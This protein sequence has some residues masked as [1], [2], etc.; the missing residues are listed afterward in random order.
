MSKRLMPKL[1]ISRVPCL[2]QLMK[3]EDPLPGGPVSFIQY[4]SAGTRRRGYLL[5]NQGAMV[6]GLGEPIQRVWQFASNSPGV[7]SGVRTV[8]DQAQRRFTISKPPIAP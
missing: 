8:S 1:K 5:D 7:S 3:D 6:A 4:R 2:A